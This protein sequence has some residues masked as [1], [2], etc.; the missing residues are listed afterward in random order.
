MHDPGLLRPFFS[1]ILFERIDEFV[2]YHSVRS[3]VIFYQHIAK[4]PPDV[5]QLRWEVVGEIGGDS[6]RFGEVLQEVFGGIT[7]CVSL[8]LREVDPGEI[9]HC[10]QICEHH[11]SEDQE[12]DIGIFS[13]GYHWVRMFND[14]YSDFFEPALPRHRTIP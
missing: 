7:E 13:V 6:Y 14:Y 10:Q 4:V 3:L 5:V 11:D 8:I 12:N 2:H 1:K 9:F